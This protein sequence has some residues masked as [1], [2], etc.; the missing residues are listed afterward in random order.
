V[1]VDLKET[2]IL[3]LKNGVFEEKTSE[4]RD[5]RWGERFVYVTLR[6]SYGVKTY[7]Y[8][9]EKVRTLQNARPIPLNADMR[10]EVDGAVRDSVTRALKFSGFGESWIRIFYREE[11]VEVFCTYEKS[12]VRLLNSAVTNPSVSDV[13][14]YWRSILSQLDAD[15]PLRISYQDFDFVHPDSVLATYLSGARIGRLQSPEAMIFPFGSN[16]S[17]KEAIVNALQNRVSIIEG[18]PG[19]GKTQTILNLVANILC[20]EGATV[21]VVSSNN[22]AVDNVYEKLKEKGIGFVAANLGRRD[23]QEEFFESQEGRNVAVDAFVNTAKAAEPQWKRLA[24][25]N[26]QLQRLQESE[27]QLEQYRSELR[28]YTLEKE[29]FDKAFD[30]RTVPSLENLPLLRKSP[31]RIIDYLVELALHAPDKTGIQKVIQQIRAYLRYGSTKAIDP[32][33]ADVILELQR[34]FYASQIAQLG[35]KIAQTENA[36]RKGSFEKLSKEQKKLS[37]SALRAM[38]KKRYASIGRG[39]YDGNLKKE[40]RK[41][42]AVDY[43]VVLSTCHSLRRSIGTGR[44]L[45]YLIIDEASQVDLLAAGLALS[46]CRNLVVVGDLRQLPPIPQKVSTPVLPPKP[47]YD[48]YLHSILSSICERYQGNKGKVP[49]T[50]LREHYRCDP[51]IIE[52]CNRMFYDGILIPY[53]KSGEAPSKSGEAPFKPL[54]IFR[55]AEGN[56]MRAYTDGQRGFFNSREIAVIKEEV[57]PLWCEGYEDHQIGVTTP[58]RCQANKLVNELIGSIEADTVHK[59]QGRAKQVV[60]LTTVLDNSW[61]GS[62]GMP[63]VDDPHLVNVA[64]SRAVDRFVLVTNH[65]MLPGSKNLRELIDYMR[66]Q[67]PGDDVVDSEVISVFDLLYKQ[68][69]VRLQALKNRLV[70]H[71][72]YESENIIATVL[73][74]LLAED[75]YSTLRVQ[76]QMNLSNIVPDQVRLELNERQRAYIN[77]RSSVDFAIYSKISNRLILAIEVDG[78]AYHGNVPKQLERDTLKDEIF[79]VLG[80]PLLRLPTIGTDEEVKIR[81]AL[82][83]AQGIEN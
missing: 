13:L 17:Q 79:K 66:Y 14:S 71:G 55:T 44:L 33:N 31:E 57:I 2:V 20:R 43:P 36:L 29:H 26:T 6:T 73:Q 18:P 23:K 52:F 72:K 68:Y 47:A 30:A 70:K 21:G 76:E 38:L 16:L 41:E 39:I 42:F 69:S 81:R 74:D 51:K 40:K 48:Y 10:V 63:F 45:D 34:R 83:A 4:I 9:Y 56:H 12:R 1:S 11:N 3:L 7:E 15:N 67:Q 77:R 75:S 8:G 28:A 62:F 46:M 25:I 78:F 54:V 82:N 60:I 80:V 58:Y 19:T 27:R 35:S 59:F 64:V 65:E 49:R 37:E 61:R 50:L 24:K 5:I 32:E 53:T 22:S